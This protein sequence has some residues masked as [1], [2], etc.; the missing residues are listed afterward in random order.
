[1]DRRL[2][3]ANGRVADAQLQ[4]QVEAQYFTQGEPATVRA[5]VA[6]LLKAPA[7]ARDRQLTHGA[8]VTVYERH[9]GW[10]FVQAQAD[11]FVGYLSEE[12]LGPR[13]APTHR[14]ATRATHAYAGANL[15]TPERAFLTLGARL[16]VTGQSGSFLETEAGFVPAG[17][18]LPLDRPDP[19]PVAVSER[20]LGT[21]YL[22]GGNSA[23]GIDCSGLVQAGL[24]ACGIDCPGDSD[25]QER[26]LG[27]TLAPGIAPKRG[28]LFFWKGH[29]AW[30][31][32][33][34]TLLHANAHHMAVAYEPIADALTRIETQGDGPVTRHARLTGA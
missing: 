31:A 9:E 18:L 25:L 15:K 21:P 7:G 27:T 8:A 20:L 12:A 14:V 22:W 3:P 6:D 26:A 11:G 28:D 16:C 23:M 17:H 33:E 2:T 10:A 24:L 34:T 13:T 32:D 1:M 29:V 19:D 5:D 4:G 30:V